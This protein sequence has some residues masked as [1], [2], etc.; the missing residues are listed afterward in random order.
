VSEGGRRLPVVASAPGPLAPPAFQRIAVIGLGA[1]GASLAMA[2]RAAW[3]ASLVIGVDG[4]DVVETAIRLHAIDV[5]ADDLA[6]AGE[7]D[8]IAL[9]GSAA[10]NARVMPFLADAIAGSAVVLWIGSADLAAPPARAL[11]ARLAIVAGLPAVALRS[12][13]VT[14]ARADLF[15]G[16]T[17]TIS[18]VAA[19]DEAIARVHDLV[20]AVGGGAPRD[21]V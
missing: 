14:A 9:A 3:P 7:A 12:Q 20:R 21:T 6:I 16:R 15:H 13:G 17:W 1:V 10:E 11:P 8:L 4:H 2:L 5:G 18:A 19:G